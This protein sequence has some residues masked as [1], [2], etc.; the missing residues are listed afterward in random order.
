MTAKK[1]FL[2]CALIS[3]IFITGLVGNVSATTIY[4]TLTGDFRPA[5]PDNLIVDVEI[6]FSGN[7]A[8][9]IVDINSPLHPNIKLDQFYF[10]LDLAAGQ[11]ITFDTF[12]PNGNGG[13]KHW[14]Q[15]SG[16]NAAGSGSADFDFGVGL[17]GG[18][19]PNTNQVNNST[20]LTF[21]I[22]LNTGT[23]TSDMFLNGGLS[24]G[25]G[26]PSPG[27]QLGAHLQSLNTTGCNNC[28]DSGF[29]S[30]NYAAAPEPATMLLL[31]SGLVG[32][33]GVRR[34]FS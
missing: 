4:A 22:V 3:F 18:G 32:I 1:H 30:G 13:A 31:G 8:S 33:A 14:A 26:I 34:K 29:A 6:N 2:F 20:N 15:V 28:C 7:T 25:G 10:N 11:S 21:E 27:A 19:N 16:N 23:F 17:I 5:N 12:T 24:T 9:W